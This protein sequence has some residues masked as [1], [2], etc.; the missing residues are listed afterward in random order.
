MHP[1]Q[2]LTVVGTGVL[3]GQIAWHSAYMG[4]TVVAY[5]PD[6]AELEKCRQAHARLGETYKADLGSSDAE[7]E[8]TK[9]RLSYSTD[10][11]AAVAKADIVIESVPEI[12]AVKTA[13]YRDLADALPAHT[14]L[15]SNS[16]TLMPSD[17]AQATGRPEKY[18]ALHFANLIWKLNLVEIM[19]HA[20]TADST[21][22]TAVRFGIEIGMVPIPVARE[23]PGYVLNAWLDTM[24]NACQTLVTNGVSTPEDVDR[25]YLIAN[26]GAT[27]PPFGI[28]DVI[29]MNTMKNIWAYWGEKH[30]DAQMLRNA[31][32]LDEHF[33]S[34][35]KTGVADGEGYYRYPDPAYAAA[36]FLAI[37]GLDKAAEI[38][39]LCRQAPE[40]G[41]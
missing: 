4:K 22:E 9:A 18:C 7:I 41:N 5:N 38:A 20:G 17:F 36:D 37:P 3:G 33:I 8:A 23:N 19:G 26:R 35:G 31:E 24:L 2:N 6:P 40:G 34:K 29:G 11:A 1:S 13:T 16:S 10:L 39:A 21:Y 15:M 32:Y 27:L 12:P 14:L 28:L 25:T 30:G